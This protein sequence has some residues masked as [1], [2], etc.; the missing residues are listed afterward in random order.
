MMETFLVGNITCDMASRQDFASLCAQ[1]LREN[2]CRHIV[3]LNPEM[4]V[5]A[6]HNH[7]FAQAVKAADIRV[8]DGAGIIWAH[9]YMR[10]PSWP[11]LPSLMSFSL[12]SVER[13]TGI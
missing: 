3:T 9:W 7:A 4:V 11:L 2:T 1:W 10:S 12:H 5:E 13:I 6:Q 8:P